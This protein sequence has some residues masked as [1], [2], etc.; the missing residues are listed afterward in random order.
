MG[1]GAVSSPVVVKILNPTGK[2]KKRR[3]EAT[4][5]NLQ[6]AKVFYRSGYSIDNPGQTLD[7]K[8][9]SSSFIFAFTLIE[10]D[11]KV[12]PK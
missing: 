5:Q 3:P 9:T 10:G 4:C 12:V 1:G 7:S 6:E 2:G 11:E 8:E